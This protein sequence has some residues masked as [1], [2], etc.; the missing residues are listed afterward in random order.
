DISGKAGKVSVLHRLDGVDSPRI[1]VVG[2]GDRRKFD[3]FAYQK[4]VAAAVRA[5]RETPADSLLLT[6]V[7][8]DVAG[9]DRA[10]NL[11]QAAQI[12]AAELYQYGATKK[13]RTF[14]LKRIDIIG[15][16]DDAAALARAD[17][18]NAG[19]AF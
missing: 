5:V 9:R 4:A 10:W 11:R 8:V 13:P 19:M 18:L 16:D 14:A 12:A 2:L 7:D 15:G 1:V 17:A 6:L 3:G